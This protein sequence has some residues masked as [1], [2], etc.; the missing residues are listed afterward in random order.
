MLPASKRCSCSPWKEGAVFAPVPGLGAGVASAQGILSDP[1]PAL[2][3]ALADSNWS[4]RAPVRPIALC[5]DSALVLE[6]KKEAVR[7]RAAAAG[8]GGSKRS[9]SL[10][11]KKPS[12]GLALRQATE[13]DRLPHAPVQRGR[14]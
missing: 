11:V 13:G 5:K 3:D 12:P 1:S 4:V 6:D 14:R 2:Q 8:I 10:P 9:K 7:F